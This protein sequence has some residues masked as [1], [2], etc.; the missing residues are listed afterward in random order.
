MAA[1]FGC[2][3]FTKGLLSPL[4]FLA[5]AHA[6]DKPGYDNA[7]SMPCRVIESQPHRF[8]VNRAVLV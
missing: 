2:A 5:S 8:Q 3:D 1:A 6:D 4:L 7:P